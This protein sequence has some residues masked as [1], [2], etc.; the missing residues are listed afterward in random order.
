MSTDKLLTFR[1]RIDTIDEKLVRLIHE[2]FEICKDVAVYKSEND[3]PM[4]QPGRITEVIAKWRRLADEFSLNPDFTEKLYQ[5]IVE[6]ACILED[7]II[8]SLAK[9]AE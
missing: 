2:R 9:K 5:L 6:E 1:E 3:I 4:M 8:D 7:E